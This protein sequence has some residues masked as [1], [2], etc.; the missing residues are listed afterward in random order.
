MT[1]ALHHRNGLR[2]GNWS[3]PEMERLRFLLPRRGVDVTATLL[4]RS[5]GSVQRKAQAL[6][7]VPPR[8]GNWTES[9]DA[10]LRD[11]WGALDIRLLALMSG[12]SVV[13]LRRRT[14]ELR[15]R[16]RSGPWSHAEKQRLKDLYGTRADADLEIC[17]SRAIADIAAMAGELCLAKDKRFAA[18]RSSVRKGAAPQPTGRA[19]RMPR[20]TGEEVARLREIY[21]DREN[22]DVARAL[23]RTVT[24]VA[25]KANQL[26]LRKSTRVLAD[27]GRTNVA[28]RHGVAGAAGDAAF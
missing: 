12:R 9:D 6:L 5:P 23:G 4:R 21:A 10:L 7:R 14:V 26:G 19:G 28:L 27:I 13:D 8:R 11:S 20:W 1:G 22:I 15:A 16:R 3:V 24:S 2:R 18:H 25:N 17:F